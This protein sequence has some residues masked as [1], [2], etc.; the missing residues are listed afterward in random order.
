M[1]EVLRRLL[2]L[3]VHSQTRPTAHGHKL[4][5]LTVEINDGTFQT[6]AGSGSKPLYVSRGTRPVGGSQLAA[7]TDV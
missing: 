2:R 1:K 5:G 4:T 6:A 3:G 7:G